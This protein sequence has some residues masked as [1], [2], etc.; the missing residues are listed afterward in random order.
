MSATLID[1]PSSVPAGL[2]AP[3][4]PGRGG[5]AY[6][7]RECSLFDIGRRLGRATATPPTL[8]K[9]VRAL[10]A[11]RGFPPPKGFR[12]VEGRLL[13]G[14]AAVGRDSRW[15]LAAV[16]AWFDN[17]FPQHAE[18]ELAA[19]RHDWSARLDRA[20]GAAA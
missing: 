3:P 1:F 15:P 14:A 16:E 9:L 6:A 19:E 12:L 13:E 11:Q 2:P 7:L 20:A 18:A 5:N 17:A 10:I 4:S 8:V